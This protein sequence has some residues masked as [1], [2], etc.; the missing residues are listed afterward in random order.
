ML[1]RLWETAFGNIIVMK[2]WIYARSPVVN[3]LN[4]GR[5]LW[6]AS[7]HTKSP[8]GTINALDEYHDNVCGWKHPHCQEDQVSHRPLRQ[9]SDADLLLVWPLLLLLSSRRGHG[10]FA[11]DGWLPNWL[12]L[13]RP[14]RS[15]WIAK[16]EAVRLPSW[17]QFLGPWTRFE[18]DIITP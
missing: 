10:L 16:R 12:Q 17:L 8:T 5:N 7:H 4:T 1:S 14:S 3:G 6:A 2:V 13:L 18:E 9:P 11:G 15:T